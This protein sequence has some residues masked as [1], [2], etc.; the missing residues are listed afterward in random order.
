MELKTLLYLTS[1]VV[2]KG[3][4][5]VML[6]LKHS[7]VFIALSFTYLNKWYIWT[8]YCCIKKNPKFKRKTKSHQNP[9]QKQQKSQTTTPL[10]IMMILR[11]MQRA[12]TKMSWST[13]ITELSKLGVWDLKL[14][15]TL[16]TTEHFPGSASQ[17]IWDLTC[18]EP[19]AH[20][21]L[22]LFSCFSFQSESWFPRKG[23]IGMKVEES[24]NV[25]RSVP[26][27]E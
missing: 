17:P 3:L 19:Q 23:N 18:G 12:K 16:L 13:V 15:T 1:I 22:F 9:K 7:I 10:P 14:R 2:I 20:T 5:F 24:C 11:G 27:S 4:T 25:L 26:Q 21:S 6:S 8:S